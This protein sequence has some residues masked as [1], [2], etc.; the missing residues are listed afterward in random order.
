MHRASNFILALCIIGYKFGGFAGW[1]LLRV[2]CV[3]KN[4]NLF[5]SVKIFI[6]TIIS[7]ELLYVDV[8]LPHVEH[9]HV[10][11]SL[12]ELPHVEV[13]QLLELLHMSTSQVFILFIYLFITGTVQVVKSRVQQTYDP[14]IGSKQ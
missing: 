5:V 9:P 10:Q 2:D 13:L 12:A 3:T 14:C 8:E 11:H 6:I 1:N 7:I 4:S